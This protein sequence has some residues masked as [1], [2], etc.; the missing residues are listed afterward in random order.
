MSGTD[1]PPLIF[2]KVIKNRKIREITDRILP[3]AGANQQ[4]IGNET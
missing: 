3:G 2:V 1:E 4:K